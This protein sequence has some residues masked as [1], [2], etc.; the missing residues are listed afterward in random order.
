MFS[1]RTHIV[2]VLLCFFVL[3]ACENIRVAD[4]DG[5]KI[6]GL[7]SGNNSG[8]IVDYCKSNPGPCVAA[9][10]LTA[11]TVALYITNQDGGNCSRFKGKGKGRCG[12]GSRV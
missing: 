2:A 4:V 9:T 8:S 7:A 11:A 10:L 12:G 5:G 1:H 6:Y 3:S